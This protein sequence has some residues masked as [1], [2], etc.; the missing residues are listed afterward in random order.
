MPPK[1]FSISSHV[2]LVMLCFERRYPQQNTVA[3]LKAEM[4]ISLI[5]KITAKE[6]DI[7]DTLQTNP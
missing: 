7:N 3:T 5:M 6:N 2:M 4:L 1:V